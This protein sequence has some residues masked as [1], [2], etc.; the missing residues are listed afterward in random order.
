M[1]IFKGFPTIFLFI[2]FVLIITDCFMVE[3]DTCKPS[4]K[5]RGKKPL[6]GQ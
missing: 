3:A 1:N 4:G 2:C 5:L 6:P